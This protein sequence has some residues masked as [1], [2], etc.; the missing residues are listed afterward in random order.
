MEQKK[1]LTNEEIK[2]KRVLVIDNDG[3]KLGEF[4][5]EDALRLSE[6]QGLDLV[7]VDDNEKP[8]CRIMDFG[9]FLYEQKKKAKKSSSHTIEVKEIQFGFQTEENYVNIKSNQARKFLERGDKVKVVIKFVGREASHLNMIR[10]KCM[11]FYEG[12]SDIADI[13]S[14]PKLGDRQINMILALKK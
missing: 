12:L 3:N 2:A 13:E 5:R 4:L 1:F 7:M 8:V 9:K 14:Q 6:E 11:A 10:Q